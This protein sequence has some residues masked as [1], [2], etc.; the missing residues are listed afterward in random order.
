MQINF[1]THRM[2]LTPA[3]KAFTE[4]KF[5]KL[6]RHFH[7]IND[8]HVTFDVEKLTHLAEATILVTKGE[9]HAKSESENMYT[10][11]DLLIDKLDKQ[12]LKH[13]EKKLDYRDHE[14]RP[15]DEEKEEV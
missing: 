14:A 3:L 1:T 5:D 2:D 10:A 7:K 9:L 11:I 15:W 12:L 6:E 8:I 4:E 13:K